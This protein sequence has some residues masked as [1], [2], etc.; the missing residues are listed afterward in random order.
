MDGSGPTRDDVVSEAIEETSSDLGAVSAEPEQATLFAAS[1]ETPT[2]QASESDIASD[3]ATP[4]ANDAEPE[5]VS[6]DVAAQEPV[7]DMVSAV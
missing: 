7:N 4:I 3:T 5:W 2:E 6:I 1:S